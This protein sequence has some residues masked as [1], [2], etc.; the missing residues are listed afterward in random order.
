MAGAKLTRAELAGKI[1]D[2]H[3]HAGVSLKAYAANEYPYAQTIEGLR[4]QQQT[5]P[6]DVNVVFPF[7]ADLYFEPAA[8]L[9]GRLTPAT[10]PLSP[11]PYAVENRM[12][13]RE[14]YD[15]CP[16][17]R[18]HF[19]PFVSID[20]ARAVAEQVRDLT[21]LAALYPIYGIK[22]NPVG[23]QS[24]AAALLG[25]GAPLLDLAEAHAWPMLFHV[26]TLPGDE[27]SQADDVFQ[28]VDRRPRLRFC[29]AHCLLFRRRYLERAAATPNVWVDTAALK[30]QVDAMRP[31]IGAALPRAEFVDADYADY[32][33]VL[34]TLGALYP[35]TIIWGTD[36]PAYSWICRRFQGANIYQEF[37]LKGQY[38]DEV[39]ALTALPAA[40]RDRVG[41]G[42]ARDFLFGTI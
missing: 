2:G 24:R 22:V 33:Q 37:N 25:P 9:T 29:L 36:S 39:A 16:E 12:L 14:L 28:I 15:Y 4:F 40:L 34:H 23:C 20:P 6:V 5:G 11:I 17:L 10:T 18:P 32:R 3:S 38:A 7:T 35:D 31:I 27:Y 42:N 30:I 1:I 19:L 26:T 21:E 13:L 41:G 8:L